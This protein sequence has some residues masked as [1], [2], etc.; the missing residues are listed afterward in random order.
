[1]KKH[2]FPI[3]VL[4]ILL[5]VFMSLSLA[6]CDDTPDE[7]VDPDEGKMPEFSYI[8]FPLVTQ[9]QEIYDKIFSSV[10]YGNRNIT[11]EGMV[12]YFVEPSEYETESFESLLKGTFTQEYADEY[13]KMM[14]EG[15]N[16]LY[17]EHDG[18]LYV[19]PKKLVDY[20]PVI[21]IT[22]SCS[23]SN[24]MGS[25]ATVTIVSED[26]ASCSFDVENADGIWYLDCRAI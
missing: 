20:D 1:M 19:N 18:D 24:Y 17:I 6:A 15:D 5:A 13:I 7:Y 2:S 3:K 12:Y 4:S 21:Y 14:Y 22:D 26:G 16:P 25:F 9:A 11:V 8:I 23:V 10:E